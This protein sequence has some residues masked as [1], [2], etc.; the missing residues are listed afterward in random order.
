M[1]NRQKIY[2]IKARLAEVEIAC[3]VSKKFT[4]A[5]NQMGDEVRF[6]ILENKGDGVYDVGYGVK[7]E[8]N[9]TSG[10]QGVTQEV[11]EKIFLALMAPRIEG[12][13]VTWSGSWYNQIVI[14]LTD[15]K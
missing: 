4:Q 7:A 6:A 5:R 11:G 14:T 9:I 3:T 10:R 2:A 13:D 12:V 8:D 15:D 1:T